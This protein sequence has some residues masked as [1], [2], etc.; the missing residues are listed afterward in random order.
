MFNKNVQL[1]IPQQIQPSGTLT[2]VNGSSSAYLYTTSNQ[3][4]ALTGTQQFL[5]QQVDRLVLRFGGIVK[6][7]N[8]VKKSGIV[9]KIQDNTLDAMIE[10]T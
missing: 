4:V 10:F 3:E 2:T 7:Q 1:L 9:Y 8:I 6:K 5:C